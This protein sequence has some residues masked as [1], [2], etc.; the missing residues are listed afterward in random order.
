M[1]DTIFSLSSGRGKAGIAVIRMSGPRSDAALAALSGALPPARQATLI[2]L[3]HPATGRILDRALVLRFAQGHSFTGEAL[4]ELHVHGGSAVVRSVLA[5]LAQ[6]PGLRMAQPGEFTRQALQNGRLDLGQVEA[7]ADL[8]DADTERQQAHALSGLAGMLGDAVR[9]WRAL[10]LE[11]KAMVAADIDFS[12]EGDVGDS[13]LAGIDSLL[14]QLERELQGALLT[15]DRGRIIADGFRVAIIGRPNVG[16]STLLNALARR[17]V[18]IVSE[19]AGTTRDVLEVKL[20][21]DGYAVILS[22]TA[23]LRET[24][25][26][27]ERIGI[28]RAQVNARKADLVLVLDDG[29]T[30][31]SASAPP[32]VPSI[33]VRTKCDRR[34]A[35]PGGGND[36]PMKISA[37][38]GEGLDSLTEQICLAIRQQDNGEAPLLTHER[39]RIGVERALREVRAALRAQAIGVEFLDHHLQAMDDA[40]AEVVGLIGVEE[41]LGS[42]F[43]RFC[44]GK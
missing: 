34:E 37:L 40:L 17:D 39:Q 9:G 31:E 20:D 23:G 41:V 33:R 24:R 30:G 27:V 12:D 1:I 8:I 10:L 11:A 16:K 43:N 26:P 42:V 6:V 3:K 22:D 13:P 14:Q 28:E 35:Q 44:I 38:T 32:G 36:G 21:I 2:K 29:E 18:A 15:A 5:A 7:L 25:D 19:H 4:V